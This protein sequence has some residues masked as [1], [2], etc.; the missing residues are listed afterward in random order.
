MSCPSSYERAAY[1]LLNAV[2]SWG[3]HGPEHWATEVAVFHKL[4]LL[5]NVKA[6]FISF[7]GID[8]RA[9][10]MRPLVVVLDG[11]QHFE[12]V[13][14]RRDQ[15]KL[16]EVRLPCPCICCSWCFHSVLPYL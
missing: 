2:S 12:L 3:P 16:R 5:T 13:F 1:A 10:R 15:A 4:R 11:Q 14:A 7:N 6:D 8:A 9:E